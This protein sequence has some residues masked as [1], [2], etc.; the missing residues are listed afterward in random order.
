MFKITKKICI[1]IAI[2]LC[3]LVM[4][5]FSQAQDLSQLLVQLNQSKDDLSK[6]PILYQIGLG[7]QQKNTHKK[8]IEYFNKAN[9][10]EK[11][12]HLSQN[13]SFKSL[14]YSY[15]QLGNYSRAIQC[16][17]EVLTDEG[18]D[19][20]LAILNELSVL[21]NLNKAYPK[22][23]Y[24]TQQ[25]LAIHQGNQDLALISNTYNNL[26]FLHKKAGNQKKSLENY[27]NAI[28]LS[29]KLKDNSNPD[30]QA[31]TYIN[32]GVAY[33]SL[34]KFRQARLYYLK[35]LAIREK[36]GKPTQ[37]ADAYNYLAV[38]YYLN[39]NNNKAINNVNKA[40]ELAKPL[41][42][43][44]V[45]VSSYKLLADI[46]Q[47]EKYFEASQKYFKK[48]QA[49]KNQRAQKQR[50]TQQKILQKQ[51]EVEQE[52]SKLKDLIAENYRKD[53][54]LKQS[55]L[56]R[57]KQAQA[58]ELQKQQLALLK[59]NQ[60]LQKADLKNKQLEKERIEQLLALAEQQ[61]KIEKQRLLTQK[62]KQEAEKQ[63]LIAAKEKAERLQKT[64]A[65]QSA[66][67][68][69]EYHQEQLEQEKKLRQYS[70]I[71]LVLGSLLFGFV[72]FS[73][74]ASQRARKK[75]K[76]QNKEIQHQK[77]EILA[78]RDFIEVKHREMEFT[79]SKLLQSEHVLR[80]AYDK[81]KKSE[82]S[83]LEKN[84]QI[85]KSIV[86]A[87]T[88]QKGILP[89]PNKIQD[90]LG[91]HFIIYKPKDVVSGDFYWVKSVGNHRFVIAADCTGHGVPGAMMSMIGKSSIDKIILVKGN[92]DP[93]SILNQLHQEIRQ[94]LRQAETGNNNG[95]DLVVARLNTVD[96]GHTKITFS[97]AKNPLY[98]VKK[99]Q[100]KVE[101]LKGNR[102]SI[103]GDQ[104]EKLL[105][106]NQEIILEKGSMIY[107]GSDGFVDQNNADRKR[108]GTGQLKQLLERC[109]ELDL[110]NQKNVMTW[111]L[112]AQMKGT[113]QRDDILYIGIKI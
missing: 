90:V 101:E 75:L 102:R 47:Q 65:L 24:Y 87:Q 64:R 44:Q 57:Q 29:E 3:L 43:S 113:T 96:D 4:T 74:V 45:L 100:T 27:Q 89:H 60:E 94:T 108:F 78:Q 21:C 81:I 19:P 103:G 58:F 76:Q 66:Q 59:R 56:K 49:L 68:D 86:A 70:N 14:G 39:G 54:E 46:Y 18:K 34:S 55:K 41:N 6:I 42:S 23:I 8:A 72:L 35:A 105:F 1:R 107:L 2:S 22:A 97:G 98:Y 106:S 9:E 83:L 16:L 51:V 31:I 92:L 37:I 12:H 15:K 88:I 79:N 48:Y 13:K 104:N 99:G 40:I 62:Q 38:N 7:Y 50:D 33:T 112:K 82:E 73:F 77:E 63:K 32:T 11:V 25:V 109:C 52:E 61:N 17:E 28:A 10:L 95:M 67:K 111:A 5:K 30:N 20:Q 69:K 71:A 85:N 91:E 84:K 80:K 110:Q 53:A 93:A 26:G 36:E